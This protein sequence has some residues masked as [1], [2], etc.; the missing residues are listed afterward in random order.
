MKTA[1][2]HRS[3]YLTPALLIFAAC[4][5]TRGASGQIVPLPPEPP[6][7]VQPASQTSLLVLEQEHPGELPLIPPGTD[8]SHPVGIRP[9][10]RLVE[11]CIVVP[12]T[13]YGERSYE[14]GSA[15]PN[16]YVPFEFAPD[17]TTANRQGML[18]AMWV[19][20][21]SSANINFVER[22]NN[23]VPYVYITN[24]VPAGAAG[25]SYG[26]GLTDQYGAN[27][28]AIKSGYWDATFTV[29]H[30]L[31]HRLGFHHEQGRPDRHTYVTIEWGHVQAGESSQFDIHPYDDTLGT[32]YDYTSIM[33]YSACAFST[34]SSC[35]SSSSSCRTITTL[36]P[37]F[38]SVLGQQDTWG[39]Y[40]QAD[41]T[42][43]YGSGSCSYAKAGA[44]GGV[45][46]LALPVPSPALAAIFANGGTVWCHRGTAYAGVSLLN[47]PA[48]FRPHGDG[49]TVTFG[50]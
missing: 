7:L 26:V 20:S 18:N 40:D 28:V 15:W 35:S 31:M 24:N 23:E 13:G 16:G 48:T 25:V 36:D 29:A 1:H 45:G 37:A 41:L 10:Y 11:G 50:N 19:V 27:E 17:V 44:A 39:T 32:P 5:C 21:Q 38:Q 2:H 3:L 42:A 12:D 33:H 6:V 30:E 14:P 46:S 9:G 4:T 22:A 47:T 43:V 8:A 49:A 34:C